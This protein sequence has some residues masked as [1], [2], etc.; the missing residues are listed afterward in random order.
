MWEVEVNERGEMR[1]FVLS[2]RLEA[3][4]KEV[5]TIMVL[6]NVFRDKKMRL[7]EVGGV[8]AVGQNEGWG[9]DGVVDA[10]VEEEDRVC[11]VGEGKI[12]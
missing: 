11:V 9:G 7:E 2:S 4:R 5:V 10:D 1:T 12:K 8:K 3:D 6:R